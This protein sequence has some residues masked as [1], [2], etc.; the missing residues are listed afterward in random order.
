[1]PTPV[2]AQPIIAA[3]GDATFATFWGSAKIP[4]PMQAPRIRE[5]RTG[6][7]TVSLLSRVTFTG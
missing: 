6:R 2:I 7:R 1:M 5:I 3:P 4:E